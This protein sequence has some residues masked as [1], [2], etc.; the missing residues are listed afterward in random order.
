MDYDYSATPADSEDGKL[1]SLPLSI[2]PVC[3]C[4]KQGTGFQVGQVS[5][6]SLLAAVT[7][8]STIH[9]QRQVSEHYFHF[10]WKCTEKRWR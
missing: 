6:G 4:E 10:P 8:C 2:L 7:A 3:S 5:E 1:K 9:T